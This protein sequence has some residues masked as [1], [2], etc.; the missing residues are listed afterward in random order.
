MFGIPYMSSQHSSFS[1]DNTAEPQQS[2]NVDRKP[3][4]LV[5]L[6]CTNASHSQP[7]AKEKFRHI[8]MFTIVL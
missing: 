6:Y 4:F 8:N 1:S 2:D 5:A 3:Y 7:R